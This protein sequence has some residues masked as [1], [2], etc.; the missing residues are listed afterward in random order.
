M[1]TRTA[2]S[3]S[4]GARTG[5]AADRDGTAYVCHGVVWP[6]RTP[7]LHL[8]SDL[9]AARDPRE[10]TTVLV[11]LIGAPVGLRVAPGERRCLGRLMLQGPRKG[12]V[13]CPSRAVS[14]AGFQCS[15]CAARDDFRFAHHAHRGGHVPAELGRYL[16]QPHWVYVATFAD[17]TS[18]VGTAAAGRKLERLDEQGAVAAT[19]V[20]HVADGL[21]ARTFEDAVTAAAGLSQVKHRTAKTAALAAPASQTQIAA[22]HAAAVTR[23]AAVLEPERARPGVSLPAEVWTPPVPAAGFFTDVPLGGRP[24]YPQPLDAGDHGLG[25]LAAVGSVALAT[26]ATMATM[27]TA[28]DEDRAGSPTAYVVDLGMLR[29]RSVTVG[30]FRSVEPP[31]Q[32]SLF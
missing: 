29:G 17:A 24:R 25:V 16:A 13:S 5:P 4:T 27:A 30:E 21:M 6:G 32:A 22:A 1:T 10:A 2:S 18:K 28:G 11:P 20:A 8:E 31:F 23:A 12:H 26:M 14:S 9:P 15:E 7:H 19:Y 3:S